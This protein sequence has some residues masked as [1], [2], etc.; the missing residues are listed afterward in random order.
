MPNRVYNT[1]TDSYNNPEFA[2]ELSCCTLLGAL[3]QYKIH[4]NNRRHS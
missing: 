3:E 1:V 2:L 4:N